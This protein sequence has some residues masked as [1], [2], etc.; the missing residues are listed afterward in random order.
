MSAIDTQKTMLE[1]KIRQKAQ[2]AY[3]AELKKAAADA[4]H[5]VEKARDAGELEL[6]RAAGD[7]EDRAEALARENKA[8]AELEAKLSLLKAKDALVRRVFV[9][10]WDKLQERKRADGYGAVVSAL[11]HEGVGCIRSDTVRIAA[12]EAEAAF[13]GDAALKEIHSQVKKE[14]GRDVRFMID[15]VKVGGHGGIVLSNETG[16]LVYDNSWQGR[17]DRMKEE[18]YVRVSGIIFKE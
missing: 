14:L 11:V 2:A 1:T 8:N 12:G 17:F 15:P 16:T 7:A 6:D 13:L 18:L 5:I 4:A 3:D 9:L 10:M